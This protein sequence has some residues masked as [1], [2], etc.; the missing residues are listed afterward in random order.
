MLPCLSAITIDVKRVNFCEHAEKPPPKYQRTHYENITT[1]TLPDN[2]TPLID[3]VVAELIPKY[4]TVI[5]NDSERNL[6]C[7]F[8]NNLH[9][10]HA[11]TRHR[12]CDLAHD[13]M[14]LR[15]FL[16]HLL[17]DYSGVVSVL[18]V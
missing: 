1:F 6:L 18:Y 10:I 13:D 17:N 7:R 11:E 4:F 3:T 5:L 15:E 12:A 2:L 16:E 8:H 9:T 14:V